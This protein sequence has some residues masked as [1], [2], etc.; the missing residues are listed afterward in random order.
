M[1]RTYIRKHVPLGTIY[2]AV[3]GYG[4][5]VVVFLEHDCTTAETM[6]GIHAL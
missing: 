6:C 5:F 4:C 2:H 3:P 1:L